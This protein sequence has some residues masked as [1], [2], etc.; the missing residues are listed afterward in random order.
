MALWMKL[1]Q[2]RSEWGLS[3]THTP[4][5]KAVLSVDLLQ[6]ELR[7]PL[8]SPEGPGSGTHCSQSNPEVSQGVKQLASDFRE[9]LSHG[10]FVSPLTIPVGENVP[11]AL[12][13]K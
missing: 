6:T 3:S 7:N 5:G 1:E 2:E 4:S 13:L 12:T 8:L 9:G 10:H 11:T